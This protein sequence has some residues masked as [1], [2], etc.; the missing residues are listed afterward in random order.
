MEN[1]QFPMFNQKSELV[2][3]REDDVINT[4]K[5]CIWFFIEFVL[6]NKKTIIHK[7]RKRNVNIC[8]GNHQSRWPIVSLSELIS[9]VSHGDH[10]RTWQEVPNIFLHYIY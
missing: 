7:E 4:K 2:K 8:C 5:D 9:G 3:K 10:K 6:W 1:L